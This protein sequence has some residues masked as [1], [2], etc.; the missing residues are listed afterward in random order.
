MIAHSAAQLSEGNHAK[1]AVTKREQLARQALC[2]KQ[3]PV[4]ASASTTGCPAGHVLF[5]KE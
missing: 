1:F 4:A 5:L 2:Q 3:A